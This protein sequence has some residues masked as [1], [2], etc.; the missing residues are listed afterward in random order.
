MKERARA[1][2]GMSLSRRVVV[3]E[4]N[5]SERAERTHSTDSAVSARNVDGGVF[6]LRA[7]SE[8]R[9]QGGQPWPKEGALGY[10]TPIVRAVSCYE[11]RRARE[12]EGLGETTGERAGRENHSG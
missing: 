2:F 7:G 6:R 1:L 12:E 11:T 9:R 3:H 5:E 8:R 4:P 10:P